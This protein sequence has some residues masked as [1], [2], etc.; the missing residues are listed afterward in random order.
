MAIWQASGAFSF[1]RS[2]ITSFRVFPCTY[3][4][5]RY[6]FS[7]SMPTSSRLTML[8]CVILLAASASRWKRLMNSISSL[9]SGRRTFT[10]TLWP[11][12][13]STAR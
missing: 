6:R 11:V 3:S 2:W 9:N 7:P 10:A 13:M 4:M 12:R 5:T 8:W 1:P